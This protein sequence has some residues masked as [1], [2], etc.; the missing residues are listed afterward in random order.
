MQGRFF[1]QG[2]LR[3]GQV[4]RLE[5]NLAIHIQ[6]HEEGS[7]RFQVIQIFINT[8][9]NT[10]AADGDQIG[11]LQLG[12]QGPQVHVYFLIDAVARQQIHNGSKQHKRH[13]KNGS[14]DK[15]QTVLNGQFL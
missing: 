12:G 8:N 7:G 2:R 4:L 15:E 10:T 1:H 11:R 3:G 6:H 5:G 9:A 14:V 13:H